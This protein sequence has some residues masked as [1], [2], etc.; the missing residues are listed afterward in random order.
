MVE[1]RTGAKRISWNHKT[2]RGEKEKGEHYSY[3][4]DSNEIVA[5]KT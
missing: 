2:I 4:N 5:T 1:G 3:V